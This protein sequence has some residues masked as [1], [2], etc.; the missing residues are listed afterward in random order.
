M[1]QIGFHRPR[2]RGARFAFAPSELIATIALAL[3]TAVA[4]TV[5]SIEIAFADALAGH[6]DGGGFALASFLALLIA[7]M[8]AIT[9]AATRRPKANR[10]A[11][12]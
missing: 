9:A 4:V 11:P 2:R 7:V 8:G 5:V 12:R 3:C 10:R 1:S 6:I